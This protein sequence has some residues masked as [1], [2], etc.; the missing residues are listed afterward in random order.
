MISR[1]LIAKYFRNEC[2]DNEKKLVLEYFRDN[3]EEWNMYMPEEEWDNFVV[4][5]EVDPDLSRRMFKT[6]SSQSFRKGRRLQIAWLA[7]AVS[8]GV[9]IGL[10]W[11]YRPAARTPIVA[12][13]TSSGSLER[14]TEKKNISNALMR[15]TLADGSEVLLSPN[16]SIRFADSFLSDKGRAVYLSGQALFKIA[17]DKGNPFIVYADKLATTVLGTSFTVQSFTESDVIKVKL[18]EGKVQVSAA[19]PS[20]TAWKDKVVLL[21]GEELTYSKN[22][23]QASIRHNAPAE[24]LVKAGPANTKTYT[25]RRPDWYTFDASLLSEVLDQLS[26]YYQVDIYYYPSDLRN[27]YFSGK[28]HKTDSLETILKDIALLNQLTI[29]KKQDGYIIRKTD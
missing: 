15:I 22:R 29:E 19:D 13:E 25:V 11:M 18:H 21:S 27:K 26:S 3:P 2:N 10:L 12:S 24:H 14:M 4:N 20:H 1:E 8:A 17:G 28:L 9:I 7:A 6:V 23:M 16:S 5:Q